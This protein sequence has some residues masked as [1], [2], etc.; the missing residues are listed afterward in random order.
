M[1]LLF[2]YTKKRF[3]S[4][5]TS[6]CGVDD[7][8][9]H[10]VRPSSILPYVHDSKQLC[11]LFLKKKSLFGKSAWNKNKSFVMQIVHTN[12]YG[13]MLLF[14]LTFT[15]GSTVHTQHVDLENVSRHVTVM[16]HCLSKLATVWQPLPSCT[17]VC[18]D[19][20]GCFLFVLIMILKKNR[21]SQTV[22]SLMGWVYFD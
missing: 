14:P 2:A 15:W 21:L 22:I 20:S 18:V 3:I 4:C 17:Q 12:G 7:T 6:L 13:V 11:I 1:V 16:H 8:A 10:M 5:Y 19:E 9:H